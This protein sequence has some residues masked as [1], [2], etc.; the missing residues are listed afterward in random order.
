MLNIQLIKQGIK[1]KGYT[2]ET[3]AGLIG[4]SYQGLY[5]AFKRGWLKHEQKV[6]LADVLDIHIDEMDVDYTPP[7]DDDSLNKEIDLLRELN[8][9]LHDQIKLYKQRIRD[10]ENPDD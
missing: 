3:V 8:Q 6:K 2:L 4:I 5:K 7:P 9:S 1:S 10:L